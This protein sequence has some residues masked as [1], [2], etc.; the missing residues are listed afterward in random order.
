MKN[1]GQADLISV[2]VGIAKER[3]KLLG[4]IRDLLES[5]KDLE[6]IELMKTYCGVKHE[7]GNR[8]N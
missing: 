8:V 5:G 7:K 1:P 2:A 4:R 3:T 6:A